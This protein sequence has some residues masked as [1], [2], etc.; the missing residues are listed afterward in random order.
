MV[1]SSASEFNKAIKL[2]EIQ[3]EINNSAICNA[4]C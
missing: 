3:F 1:V 2:I 4:F